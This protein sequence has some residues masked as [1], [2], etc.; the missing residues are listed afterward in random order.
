M[1]WK[2][3]VLVSGAGLLATWLANIPSPQISQP[4]G[5]GAGQPVAAVAQ[6]GVS[7][8]IQQLA[9]RLERHRTTG[10]DYSGPSR[11]PFRFRPAPRPSEPAAA[12]TLQVPAVAIEEPV[13]P[14]IH[15]SGVAMDR[16]DDVDVWTAILSVPE[17][18]VLARI[19]DPV[20]EGWTVTKIGT[21][22]VDL[23]RPDGSM[24]T[25]PLSGK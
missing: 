14:T 13:A 15:L 10:R 4:A 5:T 16:V 12:L 24:M 8:E 23:T 22:S 21:E 2:S 7:A 19:G 25:L 11:D 6:S 1:N 18:V 9:D 20:G 3:T 17:G